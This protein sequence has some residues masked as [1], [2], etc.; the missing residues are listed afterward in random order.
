MY[1]KSLFGE[2]YFGKSVRLDF[3][4]QRQFIVT[5]KL[6]GTKGLANKP[7]IIHCLKAIESSQYSDGLI[8][9]IILVHPNDY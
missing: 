3:L 5:Q 2:H 1:N 8:Q 9:K 7:M 4:N 6:G